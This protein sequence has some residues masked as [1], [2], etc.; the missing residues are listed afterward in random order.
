MGHIKRLILH[1]TKKGDM[2]VCRRHI[3]LYI[4]IHTY[5]GG[6]LQDVG[7]EAIKKNKHKAAKNL[8]NSEKRKQKR[9]RQMSSQA[10]LRR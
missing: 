1:K 5:I 8:R 6:Q 4:P 3:D 9:R 2:C 10:K 7:K